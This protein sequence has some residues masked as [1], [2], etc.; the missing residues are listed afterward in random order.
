MDVK[1]AKEHLVAAGIEIY[2]T[3]SNEIHVA[4]RVRVH[5]M[6]SGVRVKFGDELRVGFT[7][8]LQ[9]SDFPEESSESELFARI[10]GVI[11]PQAQARGYTETWC[12]TTH[13]AD[14]Q[15]PEKILDVWHEV[16]WTR[17]ANDAEDMI[18]EIRWAL[19]LERYVPPPAHP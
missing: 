10:R 3:R 16:S 11:G 12:G 19:T 5:I 14:P 17:P 6:D 15:D 2:R 8:R 13:V 18:R 4:E 7:A 9:R 1:K